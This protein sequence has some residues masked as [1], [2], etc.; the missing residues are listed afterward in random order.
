MGKYFLI[1]VALIGLGL[2]SI[3]RYFDSKVENYIRKAAEAEITGDHSKCKFI[4]MT[5]ETELGRN[6]IDA[7]IKQVNDGKTPG[8]ERQLC[9]RLLQQLG[10][11]YGRGSGSSTATQELLRAVEKNIDI[12]YELLDFSTAVKM[13]A[14]KDPFKRLAAIKALNYMKKKDG[15]RTITDSLNDAYWMVKIES[16]KALISLD[17]SSS[18]DSVIKMIK[19]PVPAVSEQAALTS[20]VLSKGNCSAALLEAL[21]KLSE[22]DFSSAAKA[23]GKFKS[24]KI[25]S[26]L[27]EK[28]SSI[29]SLIAI[30]A[31]ASLAQQSNQEGFD[32]LKKSFLSG[33]ASIRKSTVE[34][35]SRIENDK[36]L[37]ILV[38]ASNDRE[39]PVRVA[40]MNSLGEYDNQKALAILKASLTDKEPEVICAAIFAISKRGTLEAGDLISRFFKANNSSILQATVKASVKLND[41]RAVP[42]LERLLRSQDRAVRIVAWNGLKKLTGK[43]YILAD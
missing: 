15:L 19:D 22:T 41:E 12:D 32:F 16:L 8:V 34:A 20:A 27:K 17:A 1:I 36:V 39:V 26:L 10:S 25:N 38:L 40:A 24:P 35:M 43:E 13:A 23:F 42:Y 18:L 31:A 9:Q 30:E 28:M 5:I 6:S 11:K 21:I 7:L 2:Y 33:N 4:L 37:T 14:D 3:N 29:D